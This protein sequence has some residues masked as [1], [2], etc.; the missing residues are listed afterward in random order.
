MAPFQMRLPTS[1]REPDVLFAATEH[2]DRVRSTRVEGPADLVVEIM[3]PE[4]RARDRGEKFYE[5]QAGGVGEYW[6]IDPDTRRAE[7]YQLD[8]AGIYQAVLPGPDGFYHARELAGLRLRVACLWQDPLPE[9]N[10]VMLEID[11]AAYAQRMIADL[12]GSGFLPS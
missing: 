11:G 12:T 1:G 5:Y 10:K 6:L 9:L 8:D 4:S 3:S 7:F 2:L